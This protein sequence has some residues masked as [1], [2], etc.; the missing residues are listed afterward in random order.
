MTTSIVVVASD[1]YMPLQHL[2]GTVVVV[3]DG[4]NG[5][6]FTFVDELSTT[7]L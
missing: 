5:A 4:D 3:C 7:H 6:R 2:C 1:C